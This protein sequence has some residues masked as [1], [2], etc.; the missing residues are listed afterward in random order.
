MSK[1]PVQVSI[2]IRTYNEERFLPQLLRRIWAQAHPSL[3]KEVVVVDSGSTDATL[4]IA[5]QYGC[6]LAHIPRED[7]SF[8]RSLNIGCA[9][10]SGEVLAFISGHCIP[11]N[12]HWLTRLVAPVLSGQVAYSY[13]RQFGDESTRF[14][15]CRIFAKYYPDHSQLPQDGFFCNNANAALRADIWQKYAFDEDIT[16]LEDMHLARRLVEA[17]MK[18]GYVADAGVYH[19]HNETW[20]MV[21]NRFEREG[22]ALRH[23][24]PDIHISLADFLRY[25]FSSVLLDTGEAMHGRGFLKNFPDI[26]AYRFAQYWGGYKGNRFHRKMSS[27]RKEQYFYPR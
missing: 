3:E 11:M 23:V 19:L 2:I 9:Q 21:K 4:S 24:M 10:A 26:L 7:F 27:R 8:G 22:L 13:G 15:E 5:Q 14:S 16:G 17:G 18:I 12:E 6:I 20:R 1:S 25:L